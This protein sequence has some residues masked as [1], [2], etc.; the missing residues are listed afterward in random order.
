MFKNYIEIDIKIYSNI[1]LVI[2]HY[3]NLDLYNRCKKFFRLELLDFK[4][5][6]NILKENNRKN[7]LYKTYYINYEN[8]IKLDFYI[9]NLTR[10]Q[11]VSVLGKVNDFG[12]G[13]IMLKPKKKCNL[14]TIISYIN[15]DTFKENFI[16]SGRFKIGHRQLCNSYIPNEI[17]M[18]LSF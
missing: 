9:Y 4:Y 5:I 16:Y 6:K 2:L 1:F 13:L 3:N 10:K 15:S 7:Y 11:H 14:N 18:N 17:I 12:G 8:I